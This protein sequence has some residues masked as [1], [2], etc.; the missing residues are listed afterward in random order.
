MTATYD[1]I[2]TTTLSS[3]TNSITFSSISSG[4]TDLRLVLFN[5]GD[6]GS[7]ILVRFNSDSGT[8]YSRVRLQ[9]DGTSATSSLSTNQTAVICGNQPSATN[10]WGLHTVDVFSY[11]GSTNKTCLITASE[12][13]NG[14]GSA[15]RQ[16]ALWRN[17]AAINTLTI[18]ASNNFSAGTTATLYGIK[19]E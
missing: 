2:A 16:V 18:S 13:A 17:T 4:F 3:A 7:T 19:A 10:V 6:L 5:R 11:A 14:S 1:P 12:D 9:G 15:Q 8:N